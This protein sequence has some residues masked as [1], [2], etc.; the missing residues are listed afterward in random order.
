MPRAP[1]PFTDLVVV[2]RL[3][4]RRGER[5]PRDERDASRPVELR[6]TVQRW[7]GVGGVT[8]CNSS[9]YQN[10]SPSSVGGTVYAW[11][12]TMT[13]N[14]YINAS[15][16]YLNP[17]LL[18]SVYDQI[19]TYLDARDGN[20]HGQAFARPIFRLQRLLAVLGWQLHNV[21][22]AGFE[23]QPTCTPPWSTI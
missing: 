5:I 9:I 8:W 12:G 22:W 1:I 11:G 13:D 7:E 21:A 20:R 15:L 16:G 3:H 14:G 4:V 2:W 6:G 23:P 19:L 18:P 10:L 17:P